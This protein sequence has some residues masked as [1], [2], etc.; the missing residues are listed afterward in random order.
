MAN[1][2]R[3]YPILPEVTKDEKCNITNP[4]VKDNNN[5][6]GVIDSSPDSKKEHQD[7]TSNSNNGE[8]DDQSSNDKQHSNLFKKFF[9]QWKS[10]DCNKEKE[11]VRNEI[12][13][14]FILKTGE[15]VNQ[16]NISSI[17]D[18]GSFFVARRIW[19]KS[20]GKCHDHYV[21]VKER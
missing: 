10:T 11:K 8:N 19:N 21:F 12:N 3:I 17:L 5:C 9:K 13:D 6:S 2:E 14:T 20:E 7:A 4:S 1:P 16:K 18:R 15:E